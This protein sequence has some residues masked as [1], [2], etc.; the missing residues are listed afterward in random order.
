MRRS[1][2]GAALMLLLAGCGGDPKSDPPPS[3][4]PTPSVSATPSPPALPEAAKANTKAGAIA[5]V[6]HYVDLINY[7]QATGDEAPLQAE[8]ADDCRSCNAVIKA[9]NSIYEGGG[10]VEGGTWMV[11]A[12][13]AKRPAHKIWAVRLEGTISPSK[14]YRHDSSTPEPGSGGAA[15]GEFYVTFDLT[16]K[17]AQWHTG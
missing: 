11:G 6:R 16:W 15:S 3:T 5:F 9:A 4:S 1:V 10:H 17:V 13:T 12:V 7:L 8:S 2:V 14:V